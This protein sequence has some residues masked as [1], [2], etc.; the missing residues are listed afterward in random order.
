MSVIRCYWN[1]RFRR[2][3][4]VLEQWLA[5]T[6]YLLNIS[7]SFYGFSSGR[8]KDKHPYSHWSDLELTLA[9]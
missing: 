9:E 4:L 5:L 2:G 1:V 7:E 8:R 3:D 6:K